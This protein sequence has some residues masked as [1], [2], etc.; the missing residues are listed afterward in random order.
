[1]E[2]KEMLLEI[3]ERAIDAALPA[4]GT[5]PAKLVEAMRYAVGTGGKR[6]RPLIC[7]ASSVAVGGRAEDASA[8]AAAI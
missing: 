5:R 2:T 6:I 4:E 1:M 7:L 8:A 3:A